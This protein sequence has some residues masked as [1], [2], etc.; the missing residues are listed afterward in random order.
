MAGTG[1]LP[2]DLKKFIDAT[3]FAYLPKVK[4]MRTLFAE[5]TVDPTQVTN[6]YSRMTQSYAES[7]GYSGYASALSPHTV[8]EGAVP[9]VDDYGTED[10]TSTQVTKGL[11]FRIDRKLLNS[12]LE[13][14]KDYVARH[15]LELLNSIENNVNIALATNM[16]SNAGQTYTATGGTWAT[17]GD[18]VVDVNSAKNSFIKRSGGIASDFIAL[19]P[20]NYTDISNDYR[21]QNTL[22]SKGGDVLD[23]GT[24]TPKPM[25]LDWIED[26]AVTKGTFFLGKKGMFARILISEN[27]KVYEKDEAAAGKSYSAI[28]SYIDQYPM[29]YYLMVGSGI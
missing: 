6:E 17:T 27:Y 15:S 3:F 22:Y 7:T 10:G 12:G 23:K 26:T 18:P 9:V 24:L 13:F 29:P 8:A 4:K 11:S 1:Q 20:D 28:F 5:Q 25:G 21:F 19:H 16:A 2:T 14:Q